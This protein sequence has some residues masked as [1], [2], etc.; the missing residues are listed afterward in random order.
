VAISV[1]ALVA[2]SVG[3]SRL[4]IGVACLSIGV[5]RPQLARKG[6]AMD[7]EVIVVALIDVAGRCHG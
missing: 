3:V 6:A 7:V 2:M 1:T 4:P 5:T